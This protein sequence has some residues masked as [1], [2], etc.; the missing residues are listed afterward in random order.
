MRDERKNKTELVRELRT[1]RA[2]LK[3]LEKSEEKRRRLVDE[4]CE[5]EE[6]YRSLIEAAPDV[7]YTISAEDGSLTSLNPAFERLTGWSRAEWLGKPFMGIVH[8]D[9]VSEAVETFQKALR[10][11]RLALYQLRILSKSGEY[12]VGEFTTTPFVKSGKVVGELGIGRDITER[13]QAERALAMSLSEQ[14]TIMETIPDIVFVLDLNG[15]L[16]KWN[17]SLEKV[18]GYSSE[19]LLGKP[20]VDFFDKEYQPVIAQAIRKAFEKGYNEV[21]SP[22]RRKNGTTIPY[23]WNGSVLRDGK[24]SVIGVAGV[25]RDL[26][27]RKRAEE[28]LEEKA[29]INQILVDAL[30]CVALLLQSGTREIVISNEAAV[31]VGAVS[32]TKCY[33]T[34]AQRE[35]PCPWCLAPNLWATGKAQHL[36]VEALG[37][38]W[39]AHWIPLSEDLYMH[40]AFDITERK[41]AEEEIKSLAKFPSENPNPV[42]RVDPSGVV[43]YANEASQSL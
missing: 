20:T 27:E 22:L 30:P 23:L 38:V 34:W 11:E 43:L 39:D 4:L 12:L 28:A 41:L 31:K 10:G 9:D 15:N 42:L 29:R 37:I 19:E 36:E 6:Q 21:E 35:T 33:A 40:Y 16:V 26:T 7:V 5:S 3:R 25:G 2:K 14:K 24:G 13:K 1:L 18:T 8:P 17:S 32:G